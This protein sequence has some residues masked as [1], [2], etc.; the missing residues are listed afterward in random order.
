[1]R[2]TGSVDAVVVGERRRT[3]HD[4]WGNTAGSRSRCDTTGD[5]SAS[6]GGD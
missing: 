6:G 1:M 2:C 4:V 3:N 5:G